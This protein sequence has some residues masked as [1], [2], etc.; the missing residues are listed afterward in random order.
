MT[1]KNI[2]FDM[3]GTILDSMHVWEDAAI[4]FLS[5]LGCSV[6]KEFLDGARDK[7]FPEAARYTIDKF[8]LSISSED[9]KQ[10]ILDETSSHYYN[11]LLLKPY[12]KEFIEKMHNQGVKMCVATA[13]DKTLAEAAFKRIGVFDY[14]EF[15][16]TTA[17]SDIGKSKAEP[18]IYLKA[19]EKMSADISDV[20]VF[21]DALHCV[22][23]AK[24]AGF[25]VVGVYDESAKH[26]KD[27]IME[28]V[29]LYIHSFEEII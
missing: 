18:D 22:K 15:V 27:E 6:D 7:S 9:L 2:I 17:D 26:K 10:G 8:K 4:T 5:S 11:T 23:T 14:F 19:A 29:D 28:I 1:F 3:D 12:A 13:S 21:E 16:M 20:T 24:N 25:S